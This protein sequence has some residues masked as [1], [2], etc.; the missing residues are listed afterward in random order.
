MAWTF[1]VDIDC[2]PMVVC[3][4]MHLHLCTAPSPSSQCPPIEG[5]TL[6]FSTENK[7]LIILNVQYQMAIRMPSQPNN[8]WNFWLLRWIIFMWLRVKRKSWDLHSRR[9]VWARVYWRWSIFCGGVGRCC[10]IGNAARVQSHISIWRSAGQNRQ[11]L[12][13]CTVIVFSR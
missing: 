3:Q 12:Y 8:Y 13:C 2:F 4:R 5:N 10:I 7:I 6:R 1:L 11:Y 9:T